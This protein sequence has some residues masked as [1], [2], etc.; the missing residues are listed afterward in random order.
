VSRTATVLGL[1]GVAAL[2][3]GA[4]GL[5]RA[6]RRNPLDPFQTAPAPVRLAA[7]S[8]PASQPASRPAAAS[9]PASPPASA[10]QRVISGGEIGPLRFNTGRACRA[11]ADCPQS[12]ICEQDV[13]VSL[14][15]RIN[16]AYLY[17]RSAGR[18]F[19]EA[20]GIYWH[21]RG[22]T[23]YKVVAP[24]YWHFWTPEKKLRAVAPLYWRAEDHK[25]GLATTVIP[26][27]QWGSAPGEKFLRLWPI[28]F[29]SD[30]GAQG[31]SFTLF[32]LVHV[33]KRATYSAVATPLGGYASDPAT[34]ETRGDVL[35]YYWHRKP[36]FR[37]DAVWP[38]VYSSRGPARATTWVAPLNFYWRR[39]DRS[40]LVS[41]PFLYYGADRRGS[42]AFAPAP[43]IVYYRHRDY[44]FT[45]VFPLFWKFGTPQRGQ[46][47]ILPLAFAGHRGARSHLVVFP[48]L[49]HFGR[50][51][52][53]TTVFANIWHHRD[54]ASSSAGIL[55]FAFFGSDRQRGTSHAT[56]L[57]LFHYSTEA[58]GRRTFLLTPI[59][60][61][62]ND[63]DTG[64]SYTWV[65]NYYGRR[66]QQREVDTVVPLY[67]RWK[68]LGTGTTVQAI[69]PLFWLRSDV[70]GRSQVLFPA[71]WRFSSA[72]SRATATLVLPIFFRHSSPTSETTV[73]GPAYA[74]RDERGW[75]AGLAPVLFGGGGQ[76]GRY[77]VLFP[78]LWH[79]SDA[80]SSTTVAAPFYHR[81]DRR[82]WAAGLAPLLFAGNRD[83]ERHF[84]LF[85]L[86]WRFASE[87][88][89]YATTVVGPGYYSRRRDGY[90]AGLA[91]IAFFGR[92]AKSEHQVVAP[93]FWR[94]YDRRTDDETVVVGPAYR[95]VVSDRLRRY[96]FF[97]LVDYTRTTK[98]NDTVE[99]TVLPLL[100][101]VRRPG[102][103]LWVTPLGGRL[104]QPAAGRDTL[105][106]GPYVHHQNRAVDAHVVAP[107]FAHWRDA[108][109]KSST[110]LALPLGVYRTT[111]TTTQGV[112]FPLLWYFRDPKETALTVFPLY[113]RV[114]SAERD[115][116]VAFPL[117]WSFRS[118]ARRTWVV[119]PG[120]YSEG[121]KP[122][123][124]SLGVA[125]LFWYRS[126][127]A[128][129][130]LT[131]L[132]LF[133]YS[134]AE[135]EKR[136][137]LVFTL[138]A[139]ATY[140]DGYAAGLAPI[141]YLS[142][143]GQQRT[144]FIFPFLWHRSDAAADTHTN[145]V[146]P[147]LYRRNGGA[148]TYGLMPVLF[149]RTYPEG[150]S[151]TLAPVLHVGTW[152][153]RTRVLTPI[154][155][156]SYGKGRG[157]TWGYVGPFWFNRKQNWSAD[158]LAPIVWR[159]HDLDRD[160]QTVAVVPLWYSA[161]QPDSSFHAA[162]P[163]VWHSRTIG[164]E[165]T[166]VLP[167]VFDVN[168][169]YQERTTV[170]FPL[171][172]RHASAATQ[173]STWVSLPSIYVR[174]RA[175]SSDAFVFP[176]L[177]HWGGRDRST[178]VAL[179]LY[180][181]FKRGQDRSTVFFP[182]V[183]RFGRADANHWVVLNTY[184]KT[185][186]GR[187]AGT[188]RFI[189][190]PLFEVSRPRPADLS[191]DFLGGLVGYSR[192]GRN[193]V[194][195]LGWQDIWLTPLPPRKQPAPPASVPAKR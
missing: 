195:R 141:A 77:G 94:F 192:I 121:L 27:V 144:G 136:S 97:P 104:Q 189:F 76:D 181:D 3:A 34:G 65:L 98:P 175:D 12:T 108:R 120:W 142:D 166:V 62:A 115:V 170:V 37:A 125:P 63:R 147:F 172:W 140:P 35:L 179:P 55:P 87:R 183:W 30:Y 177:W 127:P 102:Y 70:T 165:T 78:W 162:F 19:T 43:P 21:Q 117:Y 17:Y 26:P 83:G 107:L 156:V 110:T 49:W 9:Q 2:L 114:R 64:T 150:G 14:Q 190:V 86:L 36:G 105:V 25:R 8:Q 88:Q 57:P 169:F 23:G 160:R 99:L 171:G 124:T 101:H 1:L 152:P 66:D 194:L 134:R 191:W 167:F 158:G 143:R 75:A 81:R 151:F 16:A 193:R 146:G 103:D 41:V 46:T 52:G 53:H 187:D 54:R 119:G 186:K 73:V 79:F 180:W 67:L 56:I 22:N 154:A 85:P 68:D 48:L 18:S 123:S 161:T 157:P 113:S 89:G 5:A 111:P 20:A 10:S 182:L 139:R 15:F 61:H 155:G 74:H 131:A 31:Q 109:D 92:S 72:K 47:W 184:L 13:C 11:D 122:A 40:H 176:L 28:A 133:H 38:L 164:V 116:D 44:R 135:K 32:P 69:T 7:A 96:G 174:N 173:T 163:L 129:W 130:S 153:D 128:R 137:L 159:F 178:T 148:R 93:L 100:R 126:T 58:Y 59:G 39:G 168:R 149:A 84:V 188:Y 91:P 42:V 185:G 50:A 118:P 90:Q 4:P 132:P 145:V 6:E 95:R 29:Y 24:F 106:V 138:F 112:L 60:M 82:G 33:A 71:V 80:A 45:T 51:D